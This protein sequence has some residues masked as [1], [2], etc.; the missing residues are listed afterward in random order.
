MVR[1]ISL[2]PADILGIDKGH[3][4]VGAAADI[5]II[6][7]DEAYTIKEEDIASKSKNTPFIG[8]QVQGRVK[9]TIVSG[10]VV[11]EC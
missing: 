3:L 2:N 9:Y 11:Y 6:D 5:A 10:E 4:S 8:R 7:P 1:K